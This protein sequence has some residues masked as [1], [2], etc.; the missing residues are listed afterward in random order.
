MIVSRVGVCNL[1][2][3]ERRSLSTSPWDLGEAT[4]PE[5]L[6]ARALEIEAG[7]VHEHDVER[8]Q[9]VAPGGEQILL[10]DV[11]HATRRKRRRGLLLLFGKLQT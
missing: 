3:P 8:G 2:L 6:P 11:L 4:P 5:R 1:T 7:R 10:Q 9:K